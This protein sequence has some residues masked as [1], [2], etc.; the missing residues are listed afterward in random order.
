MRVVC[1]VLI[2]AGSLE[3][4]ILEVFFVPLR[5]GTVLVPVAVVAAFVL[6]VTLPKLMYAATVSRFAAVMP[7]VL[8][9]VVVV[10]L[11]LGRPEGDVVLPGDA[12]GLFLL[13]GGA[14]AAA[15]GVA[16]A[17]PPRPVRTRP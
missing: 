10:G 15:F 17:I 4:A 16:R 1:G 6:N 9:L 11:S 8:W 5:I 13:F 14:A 12:V 3:A 7:A 2:G